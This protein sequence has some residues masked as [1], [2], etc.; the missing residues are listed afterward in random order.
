[1]RRYTLVKAG[2]TLVEL[3][4]V[5]AVIAVLAGILLP[6]L[7][8]ARASARNSVCTSNLHQLGV[9]FQAY[10]QDYDDLLPY[11]IDFADK[12]NASRWSHPFIPDAA[13]RIE[14]LARLNRMLP[15]VMS[16]Y[17]KD[18][19]LWHCPA[20]VGL[21]FTDFSHIIGGY[22]TGGES[23]FDAFGMSYGY[24]TELALLEKPLTSLR[25]PSKVNVLADS[26]GYW[27]TRYHRSPRSMGAGD[28]IDQSKWAFN[29]LFADWHVK[30]VGSEEYTRIAWG[31]SLADRDPFDLHPEVGGAA[32][33]GQ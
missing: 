28:V 26:A 27:H 31:E 29:V 15:E 21:A 17:V 20:D 18:R 13:D 12:Y 22:Y 33:S 14:T 23:A 24:R 4:T 9:A 10:V 30:Y 19:E 5:I 11:G 6:V 2:F 16:A 32:S 25:T 3:I 1:M 8:S 7:A